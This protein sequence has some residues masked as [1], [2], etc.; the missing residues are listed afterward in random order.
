M[1]QIAERFSFSKL[2]TYLN[3]P[4]QF[5]LNYVD[6]IKVDNYN[7]HALLLGVTLHKVLEKFF[8]EEYDSFNLFKWW[9]RVCYEGIEDIPAALL[10]TS[11]TWYDDRHKRYFYDLGYDIL[12]KFFYSN[13]KLFTK[14]TYSIVSLER[15]FEIKFHDW[16]LNGFIDK[17]ESHTA[18]NNIWIGDYKTGE[19]L[20]TQE[21]VDKNHQLTIYSLAYRELE[22]QQEQ[23]L[24]LHFIRP[25]IVM[26][27]KR[28]QRDFDRL[29]RVLERVTEKI[30]NEQFEPRAEINNCRFCKFSNCCEY[31]LEKKEILEW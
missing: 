26:R 22:Q 8:A 25:N 27:T 17:I 23:G 24:Y 30:V 9:S 7:T 4:Y 18:N 3:C 20:P 29:A 1:S 14:S 11:Y 16:T 2:E 10:D 13:K 12:N 19:W 31:S 15:P 28:E 6:K 5:K 21:Q